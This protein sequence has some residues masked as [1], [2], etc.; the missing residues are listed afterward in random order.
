M[1]ILSMAGNGEEEPLAVGKGG[2]DKLILRGMQFCGFHSVKQEEKQ[3][4]KKFVIDVD[5]WMDLAAGGISHTASYTDIYRCGALPLPCLSLV[6]SSASFI[7]S[8]LFLPKV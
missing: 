1:D 4:G 6:Q 5:A 8:N 7:E 3:L 2:G